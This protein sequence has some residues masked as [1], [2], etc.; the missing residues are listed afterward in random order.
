MDY[1]NQI[2]SQQ[3]QE[4]EITLIRC[5]KFMTLKQRRVSQLGS[6]SGGGNLDKMAKNCMKMTKSTFLGQNSGGGHGGDKPIFRVVGGDPPPPS[7]PSLGETLQRHINVR[8]PSVFG[9][10]FYKGSASN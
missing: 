4:V 5:F 8:T 7:P 9:I 1:L 10:I 3:T 2:L 6:T